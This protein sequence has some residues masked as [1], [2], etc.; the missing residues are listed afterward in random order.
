MYSIPAPD[1]TGHHLPLLSL[2]FSH[3]FGDLLEVLVHGV[4]GLD[5][6]RA[7]HRIGPVAESPHAISIPTLGRSAGWEGRSAWARLIV[8]LKINLYRVVVVFGL[9][10]VMWPFLGYLCVCLMLQKKCQGLK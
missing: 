7:S 1:F 3:Q 9:G 10:H 4:F 8:V 6:Y 5:W 2:H